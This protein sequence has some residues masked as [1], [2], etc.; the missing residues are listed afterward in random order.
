MKRLLL[1]W[2]EVDEYMGWGRY[3]AAGVV[4]S[5][6]RRRLAITRRLRALVPA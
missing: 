3:I 2:D 4:D 6:S 1:L 5:V